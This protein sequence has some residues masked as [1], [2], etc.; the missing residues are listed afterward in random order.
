MTKEEQAK[1]EGRVAAIEQSWQQ[2]EGATKLARLMANP[3]FTGF[4]FLGVLT[5]LSLALVQ[6]V[7]KSIAIEH[8]DKRIT[9]LKSDHEKQFAEL[10][11]EEKAAARD[12]REE[13]RR[14]DDRLSDWEHRGFRIGGGVQ[15]LFHDATFVSFVGDNLTLTVQDAA[16]Q[17]RTWTFK[18]DPAITTL[19]AN[20]L[21]ELRKLNL[22]PGQPIRYMLGVHPNNIVNVSVPDK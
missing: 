11:S 2:L 15:A 18:A 9:D 20:K 12:L 22:K 14:I 6:W 19:Q 10:K 8:H 4:A 7:S 5:L 16:M 1:L 21:I 3:F 13:I 17:P